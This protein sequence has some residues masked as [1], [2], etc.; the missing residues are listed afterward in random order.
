VWSRV[1]E[2]KKALA[3]EAP[4]EDEA[5]L[6]VERPGQL[7]RRHRTGYVAQVLE[8][9]PSLLRKSDL[10]PFEDERRVVELRDHRWTP[11]HLRIE[12][13]PVELPDLVELVVEDRATRAHEAVALPV[14]DVVRLKAQRQHLEQVVDRIVAVRH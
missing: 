13:Q 9:L 12:R 3:N 11:L 2:P 8:V 6:V 5:T 14:C 10:L 7:P 1:G 4:D